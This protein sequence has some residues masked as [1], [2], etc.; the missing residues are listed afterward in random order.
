MM[1]HCGRDSR[2]HHLPEVCSVQREDSIEEACLE[3]YQ[4]GMD[5]DNCVYM[6]TWNDDFGTPSQPIIRSNEPS[7]SN[8]RATA[9][10]CILLKDSVLRNSLDELANRRGR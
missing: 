6:R 3:Y 4:Q 7:T 8:Y 5:I 10:L 2:F 9:W 1:Q